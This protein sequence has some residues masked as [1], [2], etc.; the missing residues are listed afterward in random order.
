MKYNKLVRDKIPEY[1]ESVNVTY[2]IHTADELEY[3]EK[4]KAKLQEEV[5]E[6]MNNDNDLGE[7]ADILEVIEA[8]CDYRQFNNMD[9]KK[10]KSEK[11][12]KRGRFQKRIILEES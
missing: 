1:L 6:F 5:A 7:I 9:L 4:L 8:I 10:I 3:W 12:A 11:A 2:R